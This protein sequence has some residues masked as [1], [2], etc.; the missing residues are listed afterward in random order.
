MR[1]VY[2]I[3]WLNIGAIFAAM[4][5]DFGQGTTGL[6]AL[7]ASF[8]LGVGIWQVPGGILAATW[9][10]K[11]VVILGTLVWSVSVLAEAAVPTFQEE[12]LL[13]FLVGAGMALVFAPAVVLLVGYLKREAS[14]LGVGLFNSAFD[15]GGFIALFGWGIVAAALGWRVSLLIGGGIGV[16]TALLI[17][18]LVP[19]DAKLEAFKIKAAELKR[20]LA[21]RQLILLGIGLLSLSVGNGLIGSFMNYYLQDEFRLPVAEAGL[22]ASLIVVVPI[23]SALWGG[24]IYDRVRK[25]RLLM[26]V[27]DVVMG[28][29]VLVAAV[30]DVPAA[31]VC[32][33]LGGVATGLGYTVGFAAA[34]D[35]NPGATEYE[36][37]A[38]AWVNCISL[39]GAFVPP[40]VF[41]Y[42]ESLQGYSN[43]WLTGAVLTLVLALPM[44]LYKEGVRAA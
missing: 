23:F 31:I 15:V 19:N 11:K 29:S 17:I 8:Y 1:G 10:S 43:A 6:G 28:G 14:G 36:S 7:T 40:L 30:T 26:V 34:R 5:L 24:R 16:A 21:D 4:S 32:A 2:A 13:R 41:S 20:I 35:I 3:N 38:V 27:V 39:L 22:I 9:G 33:G 44:L 18:L 12:V 25:P 37:L 42:V